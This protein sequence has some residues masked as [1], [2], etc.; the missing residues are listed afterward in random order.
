MH[1]PFAGVTS[2]RRRELASSYATPTPIWP[3]GCVYL[4]SVATNQDTERDVKH[5]EEFFKRP[6]SRKTF[7]VAA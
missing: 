6:P 7:L 1:G 4:P 3:R 2:C 5:T